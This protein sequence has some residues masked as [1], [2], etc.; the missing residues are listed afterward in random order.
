MLPLGVELD[1]QPGY[2]VDPLGEQ[3]SNARPGIIHKYHGRL[4]LVVSA[5]CAVNCRYCFRRH[6]PYQDN[7]L[8]T[9][10]WDAALTTFAR[11]TASAKSF[12][13]AATRWPPTTAA[14]PG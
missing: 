1:E 3:H 14:W 11:T 10:E 4:L 9:A 5:G 13:A 2:V 6:F 8:S 7:S 12:T